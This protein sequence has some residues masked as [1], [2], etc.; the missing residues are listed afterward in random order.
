MSGFNPSKA[1]NYS[2]VTFQNGYCVNTI[3]ILAIF[4][5]QCE[6]KRP[7]KVTFRPV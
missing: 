3:T 6:I 4:K 5:I 1:Y 7:E 2:K